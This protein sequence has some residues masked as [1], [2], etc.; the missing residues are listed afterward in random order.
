MMD[1]LDQWFA[2]NIRRRKR[3]RQRKSAVGLAHRYYRPC[4][5]LL[6]TRLPPAIVTPF[7]V[8]FST[9]TTGDIAIIGNTLETASTVGNS[10]RTQQDVTNAQNGTGSFIDDEPGAR[11]M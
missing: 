3:Q 11:S 6:E 8:R 5:E 1:W 7:N 4:L 10:G 9:N 2:S